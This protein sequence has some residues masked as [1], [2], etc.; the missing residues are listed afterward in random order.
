MAGVTAALAHRQVRLVAGVLLLPQ[1]APSRITHRAPRPDTRSRR[2]SVSKGN[3][4][5]LSWMR[6]EG[7]EERGR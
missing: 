7:T 2:W 1:V 3:I 4:T 6:Y 5:A